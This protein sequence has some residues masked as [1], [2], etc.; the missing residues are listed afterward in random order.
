MVL[1]YYWA[2]TYEPIISPVHDWCR[3]CLRCYKYINITDACTSWFLNSCY[4]VDWLFVPHVGSFIW[5]NQQVV[6]V[7]LVI[8]LFVFAW[9]TKLAFCEGIRCW[10][11]KYITDEW[12]INACDDL[13][14]WGI[15]SK[16]LIYVLDICWW[17]KI[18]SSTMPRFRYCWSVLSD[19]VMGKIDVLKGKM[20]ELILC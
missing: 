15:S 20:Q 9:I 14:A 16:L 5:I 2:K 1:V 18:R 13:V 4:L 12:R 3:I 10:I 8:D 7:D 6:V 11:T 17:V 19:R